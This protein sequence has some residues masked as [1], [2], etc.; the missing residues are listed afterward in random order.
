MEIPAPVPVILKSESRFLKEGKLGGWMVYATFNPK[1]KYGGPSGRKLY[2]L[3]VTGRKMCPFQVEKRPDISILWTIEKDGDLVR[4][5]WGT[6]LRSGMPRPEHV[7]T[8]MYWNGIF[9]GK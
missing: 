8:T 9:N 2:A 1:N 7:V 6:D 4:D 5:D 3:F